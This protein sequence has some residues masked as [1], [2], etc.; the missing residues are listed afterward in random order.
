[1]DFYWL[2][3]SKDVID[4]PGKQQFLRAISVCSQVFNT[5]TESIQVNCSTQ[6]QLNEIAKSLHCIYCR[7]LVWEIRWP[8]PRVG[9]GMLLTDFSFYSRT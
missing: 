1:M 5:L 6:L 4:E 9:C 3:S 7:A 2:Y 8:W